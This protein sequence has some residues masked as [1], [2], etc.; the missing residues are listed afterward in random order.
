MSLILIRYLT[1]GTLFVNKLSLLNTRSTTLYKTVYFCT[2]NRW[3]WSAILVLFC[4]SNLHT[5]IPDPTIVYFICLTLR[6]IP[7]FKFIPISSSFHFCSEN[8]QRI[9]NLLFYSTLRSYSILPFYSNLFL[10]TALVALLS[11]L[12]KRLEN[13][14]ENKTMK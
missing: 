2:S 12:L 13:T 11:S 4:F 1:T 14:M 3:S 6:F 10:Y 8:F 5:D 7:V 9:S